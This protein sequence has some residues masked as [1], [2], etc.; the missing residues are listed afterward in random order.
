MGFLWAWVPHRKERK[1]LEQ[2]IKPANALERK[3]VRRFGRA[4]SNLL[5][6]ET[7][8]VK[9]EHSLA[10]L[11]GRLLESAKMASDKGKM[12]HVNLKPDVPP[13]LMLD[14]GIF[15]ALST[16]LL[17]SGMKAYDR[18][19][20]LIQVDYDKHR[21]VLSVEM[22][23]AAQYGVVKNPLVESIAK[24]QGGNVEVTA[25]GDTRLTIGARKA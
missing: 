17:I 6:R 24:A 25:R 8:L 11:K 13:G 7:A 20:L 23:T 14:Q 5:L 3:I 18:Q 12:V 16:I 10:E 21:G 4:A 9:K 1:A 19:L 15:P 22:P 2:E